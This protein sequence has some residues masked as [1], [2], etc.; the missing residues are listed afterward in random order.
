M[1]KQF[2]KDVNLGLSTTPK[3]LSSKYFY[4]AIGDEL[5]V[6]IM[7][8][9]EYYLTRAEFEIFNKKTKELIN[10][11]EID[12]SEKFQL[13]E[14]GAGDGTKTKE[15]LKV[16][17]AQGYNFEYVP[18]DISQHTLNKLENMLI[19]EL[20]TLSVSQ[21]QGEYFEVLSTFKQGESRKVV[22]FLGSNIGNLTDDLSAK[23]LYELGSNLNRNDR[24]LL[25]VD[26]IKSVDIVLPAYNDKQGITAKFNLNLLTRINKEL[27]ANFNVCN[28]KH[29]PEYTIEEGIA[30]SFIVSTE[31][32]EVEIKSMKRKFNFEKG[33]RIHTEISRKYNDEIINKIT[34][35]TDFSIENK[36]LDS[37]KYFADYI[38]KK[39]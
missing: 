17:V 18:I 8:M 21:R 9:P 20:P 33:E 28:F 30:K 23:F 36:I 35:D 19:K 15:L 5:F 16:L 3:F 32:Q 4:D 24:L 27:G 29:Q 14:L 31:K 12:K 22:L 13:I 10:S 1:T 11:F 2:K 39:N 37:K 25:G 6:E 34:N 7:N 26:L 38:L